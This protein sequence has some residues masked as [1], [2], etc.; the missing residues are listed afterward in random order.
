MTESRTVLWNG[1]PPKP[2]R[3]GWHWIGPCTNPFPAEWKAS[4]RT[5]VWVNGRWVVSS[6]RDGVVLA[7][8]VAED[9]N[10]W[11]YHGSCPAPKP[12][13]MAAAA[14]TRSERAKP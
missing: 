4:A 3:D 1:I 10:A 5:W 8:V 13:R 12:L 7:R 9:P 14:K 2:D 6:Q 11:V